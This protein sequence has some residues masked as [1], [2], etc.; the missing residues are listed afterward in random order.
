MRHKQS[1]RNDLTAPPEVTRKRI[2]VETMSE[3]LEKTGRKIVLDENA[4]G[5]LPLLNLQG[6]GAKEVK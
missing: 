6:I 3:V 1:M 2:F 4:D 5:I